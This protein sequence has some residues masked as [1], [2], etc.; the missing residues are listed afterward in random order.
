MVVPLPGSQHGLDATANFGS[1]AL[2]LIATNDCGP[3]AWGAESI[4]N[5]GGASSAP[6]AAPSG[7]TPGAPDGLTQDVSGTLVT[8]NWAAPATGSATRYLIEATIPDGT[9][10]ASLDTGNPATSF[11]HPNTPAGHYIVTVRAGN[12]SGFGPPSSPVTV[13]VP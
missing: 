6:A 3:S 13:I 7:P 5:V 1:Y 8:L 4:L 10:V 11:S 12:A 2:R 9:L